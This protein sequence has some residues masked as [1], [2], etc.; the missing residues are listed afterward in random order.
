MATFRAYTVP[1]VRESEIMQHSA[2]SAIFGVK[3]QYANP[4]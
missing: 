2:I 4:Y 1:M 3:V